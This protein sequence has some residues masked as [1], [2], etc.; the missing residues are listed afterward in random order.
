MITTSR[1]QHSQG[2][3]LNIPRI[4][5]G[6]YAG[7]KLIGACALLLLFSLSSTTT[8]IPH[9]PQTMSTVL[10]CAYDPV[11]QVYEV[12]DLLECRIVIGYKMGGI[13]CMFLPAFSY[14]L[15]CPH[16]LQ[17][18]LCAALHQTP[19][20][21]LP[22]PVRSL[23]ESN[24]AHAEVLSH[25][26]R[27]F[28]KEILMCESIAGVIPSSSQKQSTPRNPSRCSSSVRFPC[29]TSPSPAH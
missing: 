7:D 25:I 21:L 22:P 14:D 4:C 23:D 12:E 5:H 17:L 29:L 16:R 10:M 19:Q 28:H 13:S 15:A 9:S 20:A 24:P 2:I 26:K 3:R 6:E 27:C 8:D 18:D 1:H 11:M